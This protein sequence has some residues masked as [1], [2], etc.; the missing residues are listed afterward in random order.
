[1]VTKGIKTLPHDRGVGAGGPEELENRIGVVSRVCLFINAAGHA[2]GG[3]VEITSCVISWAP[4][5][6]ALTPE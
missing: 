4:V 5:A 6:D 1:M 3:K 2:P